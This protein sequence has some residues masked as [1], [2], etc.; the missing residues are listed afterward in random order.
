MFEQEMERLE[1][2][3]DDALLFYYAAQ[4]SEEKEARLLRAVEASLERLQHCRDALRVGDEIKNLRVRAL[5]YWRMSE[6][7]LQ[8]GLSQ[9]VRVGNPAEGRYWHTLTTLAVAVYADMEELLVRDS[10][11]IFG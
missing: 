2:E 4:C 1:H 6:H 10:T 9:F 11:E 7:L 5:E 8:E 3:I